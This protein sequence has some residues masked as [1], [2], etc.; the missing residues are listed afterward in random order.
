MKKG[1]K[2]TFKINPLI[3]IRTYTPSANSEDSDGC[4]HVDGCPN[5]I[6]LYFVTS[7]FYYYIHVTQDDPSNPKV[8]LQPVERTKSYDP[9]TDYVRH[10]QFAERLI[11]KKG[12]DTYDGKQLATVGEEEELE[13][14]PLPDINSL[15]LSGCSQ[16]DLAR[17]LNK[18]T[19]LEILSE[20]YELIGEEPKKEI[21]TNDLTPV[22][23]DNK[24][25]SVTI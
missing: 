19:S 18:P 7:R 14:D 3:K 15:A 22:E 25:V 1:K 2:M 13:K 9:H 16:N 10:L 8:Y 11:N 17:C 21:L 6:A 4:P 20:P 23:G 5:N 12:E 24:S